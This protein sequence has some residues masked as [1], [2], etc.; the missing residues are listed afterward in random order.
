MTQSKMA[1]K[2]LWLPTPPSEGC[3]SMD[4][5]WRELEGAMHGHEF[6]D[7]RISCPF[8]KAP[9]LTSKAPRWLRVWNKYFRYP[10]LVSRAGAADVAH[11][12]DHSSAHFLPRISQSV[13]TIV[14]VHDLA[15]LQQSGTLAPAQL[16]RFKKTVS[17]IREADLILADS[18]FTAE[19]TSAFLKGHYDI[20]VLPL[21]VNVGQFA[22]KVMLPSRFRLPRCARIL[23]IGSNLPRKNLRILPDALGAV[24]RAVGPIALIRVGE[25]LNTATA[26]RLRQ[27]IGTE[28]VCELGDCSDD[29]LTA[30]LQNVDVLLFPSTLEG[31]GLPLL[32]AMAAG[33][34][35][36]SSDASS[37]PEVG[38]DEVL[39]FKPG[40]PAAAAAQIT[41]LLRNGDLRLRL[42]EGG[43]N[44]ADS[45]SW[46]HHV[47][48]LAAIYRELAESPVRKKS[49]S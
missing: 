25:R 44:R 33:C 45:F 6:A 8:G 36:V 20:R 14:T 3:A 29:E 16:D 19:A 30:L 26:G 2:I 27:A 34:P 37:L 5:H 1:C 12:L 48:K 24:R 39:Y 17:H 49:H 10:R 42:I 4:R 21:G 46:A 28:S 32:E 15:P 11:I 38:G 40:E 23:S 47:R 43:R 41:S 31:F 18:Q 7:F 9:A 35:V 13:R 22:K